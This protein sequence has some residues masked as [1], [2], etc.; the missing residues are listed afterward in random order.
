[1]GTGS[2]IQ[3]VIAAQTAAHVLAVDVNPEALHVAEQNA[4]ANNVEIETQESDLFEHVT[5][6]FDLIV[7]N[8]PYLPVEDDDISE[9]EQWA[10]IA[11]ERT[12]IEQFLEAAPNHL[13]DN[14]VI[15][16]VVSSLTGLDTVK[17]QVANHGCTAKIVAEQKIPWETLYVLKISET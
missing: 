5:E 3:A 7:F 13:N 12:V 10:N 14:G 2:G 17:K 1:M 9:H 4:A 15:L 11:A 8:A 16:L 6:T